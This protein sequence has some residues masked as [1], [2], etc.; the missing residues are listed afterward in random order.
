MKTLRITVVGDTKDLINLINTKNVASPD[1]IFF[2]EN[3][4]GTHDYDSWSHVFPQFLI[5]A[6]G[7]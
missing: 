4:T 1:D 5:W 2:I 6:A 3:K 7:K